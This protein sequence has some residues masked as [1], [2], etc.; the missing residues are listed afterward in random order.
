MIHSVWL[1]IVGTGVFAFFWALR[2]VCASAINDVTKKEN[3]VKNL[4]LMQ[5]FIGIGVGIGPIIGG[6]IGGFKFFGY[7]YMLPFIILLLFSLFLFVY[8]KLNFPETLFFK[9]R[10]DIREYFHPVN[11]KPLFKNKILYFLMIIH[12]LDQFSW[13]TYYNFM[14]AVTKTV[15]GYN[16]TAV[17]FFVGM[18]GIWLIISSGIFIPILQRYFSNTQLIIISSI[19]GTVGVSATYVASF[20][21][22][23]ILSNYIIWLSALPVAAGDVILFC[24]LVSLFSSSVSKKYQGTIVGI[25]YIAGTTMWCIAAPIGGFLMKWRMNG[26]LILCPIAMFALLIFLKLSYK[27][28]WFASLNK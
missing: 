1:F 16:I 28:Q 9:N 4:A 17:G 13:G 2:P 23:Y 10:L 22:G 7:Y 3:K 18:I 25:I 8:A 5:F 27:K 20:F 15:F 6:W 19:V 24:L 26:A 21:P 14:P 11:I 12:L